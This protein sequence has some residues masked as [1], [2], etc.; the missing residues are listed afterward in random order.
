LDLIEHGVMGSAYTAALTRQLF[1]ER[2]DFDEMVLRFLNLISFEGKEE[3]K[4]IACDV[5]GVGFGRVGYRG[6][7]SRMAHQ[8]VSLLTLLILSSLSFPPTSSIISHFS[9]LSRLRSDIVLFNCPCPFRPI[10][11]GAVVS[12]V[13]FRRRLY[14]EQKRAE[15]PSQGGGDLASLSQRQKKT[16]FSK[17]VLADICEWP[18]QANFCRLVERQTDENF[19]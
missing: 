11:C 6:F 15:C 2:G 10:I 18:S 7:E 3:R 4:G 17:R 19:G 5:L 14:K 12:G 1:F 16:P 9:S 13:T 8:I